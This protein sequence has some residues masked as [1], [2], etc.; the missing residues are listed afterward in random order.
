MS[1]SS[2]RR[3]RSYREPE[4]PVSNR[5]GASLIQDASRT[6]SY[7][8]EF[9]AAPALASIRRFSFPVPDDLESRPAL[10]P[11]DRYASL[12]EYPPIRPRLAQD[13][14]PRQIGTPPRGMSVRAL[15]RPFFAHP[16][17]VSF[18]A[19]RQARREVIF[20]RTGGGGGMPPRK[21]KDSSRFGC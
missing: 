15:L 21:F 9:L 16:E 18:C 4:F 7:D 6:R 14:R 3:S 12:V 11:A 5:Q 17:A 1:R 10:G 8:D 19:R 20:A 2:R 13:A